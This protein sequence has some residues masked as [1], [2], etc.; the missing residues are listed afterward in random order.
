MTTVKFFK[1]DEYLAGAIRGL[2]A[3]IGGFGVVGGMDDAQ[4]RD[5]GQYVFDFDW[6]Q[7]E[8]FQSCMAK[9]FN[10]ETLSKIEID[11]DRE[12]PNY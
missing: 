3:K 4:L 1:K 8:L 2:A 12:L 5:K 11:G 6:A 9:F 10:E 7:Q